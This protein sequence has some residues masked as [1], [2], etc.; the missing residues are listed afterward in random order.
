LYPPNGEAGSNLLNVFAHITPAF[1]FWLSLNILDP[2]SVQTPADKP[3]GVLLAFSITSSIVL[4][5][6]IVST[7]PKISS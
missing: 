3:K 6:W 1:N 4:K 7:G 2:F 5:V